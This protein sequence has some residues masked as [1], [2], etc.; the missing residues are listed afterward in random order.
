MTKII[1]RE[2]FNQIDKK[3]YT[4]YVEWLESYFKVIL[5][6]PTMLPL[7]GKMDIKEMNYFCKELDQS[8]EQYVHKT[9][10]ILCGK[11]TEILFLI[12]D[13]TL[14]WKDNMWILGRINLNPISDIKVISESFQQ[15][16]KF[17]QNIQGRLLNKLEEENKNLKDTKAKL[18]SDIEKIIETKTTME[19][20]MYKKF[21]LIL[22]SKKRKIRE[23]Q[24]AIKEKHDTKES[25]FDVCTDESEASDEENKKSKFIDNKNFPAIQRTT[26]T[27]QK[28]SHE[29]FTNKDCTENTIKVQE[30]CTKREDDCTLAKLGCTSGTKK[31]RSSL[32]FIEEESEEEL[33]SQ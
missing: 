14:R 30:N 21:I 33:F 1:G 26:V 22:N 10:D 20:D 4:L 16:L 7:C 5:L 2:L 15:S 27:N 25:V 12:D 24:N 29:A 28:S 3:Y 9:K 18:T 11:N 17:Y 31:S 19:Q 23:I 13:T 32:N 6:E 8:F